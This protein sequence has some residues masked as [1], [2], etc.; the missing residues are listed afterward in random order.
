MAASF[1]QH[2]RADRR[3][4]RGEVYVV[5]G[6]ISLVQPGGTSQALHLV[7]TVN[8]YREKPKFV[9]RGE[10]EESA[11]AMETRSLVSSRVKTRSCSTGT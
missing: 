11:L 6:V 9:R 4:S 1:P 5:E 3:H 2:S 7:A 8:A 10:F